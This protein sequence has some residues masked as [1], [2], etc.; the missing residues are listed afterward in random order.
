[1][2]TQMIGPMQAMNRF[3]AECENSTYRHGSWRHTKS[4]KDPLCRPVRCLQK[5][6]FPRL[7]SQA[8]SGGYSYESPLPEGRLACLRSKIVSLLRNSRWLAFFRR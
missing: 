4:R 1:M 8:N 3:G 7:N 6:N 2:T 5:L